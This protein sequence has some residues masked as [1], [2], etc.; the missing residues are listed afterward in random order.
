MSAFDP[1]RTLPGS[2][3]RTRQKAR[4]LGIRIGHRR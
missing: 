4:N 2:N 1:K 3:E